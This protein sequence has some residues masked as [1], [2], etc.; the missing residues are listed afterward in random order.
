MPELKV[1]AAAVESVASVDSVPRP[2]EGEMVEMGKLSTYKTADGAL[3][4]IKA[5]Y[6]EERW[7]NK[8]EVELVIKKR[9]EERDN[10]VAR[11]AALDAELEALAEVL[12]A[13]SG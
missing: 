11:V 12:A 8:A 10:T 3:V 7:Q 2:S 4:R 9:T 5:M 13:I 6:V 1:E